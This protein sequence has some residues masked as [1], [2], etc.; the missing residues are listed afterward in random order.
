MDVG[1]LSLFSLMLV[2]TWPSTMILE[3]SLPSSSF[4]AKSPHLGEPFLLS[5]KMVMP[6]SH[7]SV[8]SV[9]LLWRNAS[10]ACVIVL[11]LP[12]CELELLLLLALV[13]VSLGCCV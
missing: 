2:S 5:S 6:A 10:I 12:S 4:S 7:A 11:V 3:L 13:S 9:A 8:A 1:A